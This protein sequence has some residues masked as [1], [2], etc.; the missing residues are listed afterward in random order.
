MKRFIGQLINDNLPSETKICV[1]LVNN[2][3]TADVQQYLIQY[4]T[5]L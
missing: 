1:F 2:S 3:I 5:D 4:N